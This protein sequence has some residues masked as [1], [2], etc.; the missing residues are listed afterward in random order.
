MIVG[1]VLVAESLEVHIPKGYIYGAMAFSLIV[2]LFNIRMR[3]NH[4]MEACDVPETIHHQNAP[5]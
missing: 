3:K 4:H 2:E 1:A 5:A